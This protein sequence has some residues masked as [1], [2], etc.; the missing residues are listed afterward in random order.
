[1]IGAIIIAP[2]VQATGAMRAVGRGGKVKA[3]KWKCRRCGYI[4][5]GPEP[6]DVC[7]ICSAPKN[8]FDPAE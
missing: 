7:P 6:P 4:H 1:L 3:N 2:K 5:D 8:L